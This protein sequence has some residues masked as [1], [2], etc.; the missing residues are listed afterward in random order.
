MKLDVVTFSVNEKDEYIRFWEPQSKFVKE[1]LNLHPVL[2]YCGKEDISLSEEYGDVHRIYC[3]DDIPTYLSSIWGYFWVTSLYPEQ[4]CI[5]S[6]IDMVIVDVDYFNDEIE[7][8]DDSS[9][10]V[11]NATGYNPIEAVVR[12]EST[13]PSYYHVAKGSVFKKVLNFNDSFV[14]EIKKFDS[15]DYSKKYNGYAN[16][17]SPFLKEVSVE[18]GGKWCLDEMYSSEL[19]I[20]YEDREIIKFLSMSGGSNRDDLFYHFH[21]P[22]PSQEGIIN[23]MGV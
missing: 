13:V 17:P 18:N 20:D 10:V 15:L 14:D 1:K 9:Y 3:G 16:N 7:K 22:Y 8:F 2:L 23:H 19:I 11:M 4:T 6:G 5:T 12:K 21:K